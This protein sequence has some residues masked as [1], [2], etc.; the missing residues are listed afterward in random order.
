M[1]HEINDNYYV[2]NITN[3]LAALKTLDKT[4][5]QVL[6]NLE[7]INN[8]IKQ[9]EEQLLSVIYDYEMKYGELLQ[10]QESELLIKKEA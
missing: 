10:T 8:S 6:E 2:K 5:K 9:E 3:S 4:K 7:R 1:E